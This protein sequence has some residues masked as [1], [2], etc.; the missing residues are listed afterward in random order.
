MIE[1]ARCGLSMKSCLGSSRGAFIE[2]ES[3]LMIIIVVSGF[4]DKR[5]VWHG[6]A[7]FASWWTI[8]CHVKK[9]TMVSALICNYN[10]QNK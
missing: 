2:D 8:M 1:R 9:I 3:P 7:T 4:Y 6:A 5:G 10:A